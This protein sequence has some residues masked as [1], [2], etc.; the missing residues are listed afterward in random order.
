[1]LFNKAMNSEIAVARKSVAIW[2][3]TPVEQ[4]IIHPGFN[5]MNALQQIVECWRF[6]ILSFEFWASPSGR[7]REWL[8]INCVLGALL[9]IPTVLILP[10]FGVILIHL[11]SWLNT[12]T[13][14]AGHLIALPVLALF[15]I[16][17]FSISWHIL[18]ALISSGH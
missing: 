15:A 18:K 13:S 8:R 9:L 5:E 12:L 6:A 1:M 10:L 4:P 7:L 16:V 2:K 3:P 17:A 14:I 11:A